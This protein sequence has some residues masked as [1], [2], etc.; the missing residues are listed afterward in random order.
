MSD[1]KAK[2]G[3]K[4]RIILI[5]AVMLMLVCAGV[6]ASFGGLVGHGP[7]H[8][9]VAGSDIEKPVLV[10]L[11]DMVSNLDTG[12]RRVSFVKIHVKLQVMHAADVPAIKE[13]EPEL[14]DIVQTYLRE[15][16]PE[17]LHGGEATYR[18]R[19]ALMNRIDARLAPVEV[20]DLLFTQ[21]L[22]Q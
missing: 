2:G 15:M 4:K 5:V 20:T 18:L 12:G 21:L 19:E 8:R 7:K 11:P 22:V 16:R 1:T 3:G 17:E 10:D 9:N 13:A 14:L 6:G